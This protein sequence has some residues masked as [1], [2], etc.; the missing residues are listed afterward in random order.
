MSLSRGAVQLQLPPSNRW[1]SWCGEQQRNLHFDRSGNLG[2]IWVPWW[3]STAGRGDGR[4][5]RQAELMQTFRM[6][7]T[8]GQEG[9]LPDGG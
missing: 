7:T 6:S 3:R 1:G 8:G 2:T 4:G 5:G 9:Y